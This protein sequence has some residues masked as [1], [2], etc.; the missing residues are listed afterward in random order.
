MTL[1]LIIGM[2]TLFINNQILTAELESIHSYD[3][4]DTTV[5][6]LLIEEPTVTINELPEIETY[7]EHQHSVP[8]FP[9]GDPYDR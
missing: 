7:Y 3:Y 9:N 8:V 6:N 5:H 1:G 2:F 4:V